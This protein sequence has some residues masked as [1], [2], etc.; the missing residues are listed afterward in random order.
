MFKYLKITSSR[1]SPTMFVYSPTVSADFTAQRWPFR[2][3]AARLLQ[4][5]GLCTVVMV[6][7]TQFSPNAAYW[8]SPLSISLTFSPPN[9]APCLQTNLT[10]TLL[11][12]R[13]WWAHN[14]NSKLL[15][16]FNSAFKGLMR[17]MNGH[18]LWIF[19]LVHFLWLL[20][21]K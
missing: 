9:A 10:L 8:I 20:V 21:N 6:W 14:N 5:Y 13:I 12:W 7:D 1:C 19:K 3:Q 4:S 11:T 15:M 18:C 17:R 16:G 2:R